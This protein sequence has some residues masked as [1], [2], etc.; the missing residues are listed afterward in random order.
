MNLAKTFKVIGKN[1]LAFLGGA[2]LGVASVI[3][4]FLPRSLEKIAAG[5][6]PL[7]AIAL[8]PV[9]LII[10]GLL[11]IVIGGFGAII[12][13]NIIKLSLKRRK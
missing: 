13:Y 6:E 1:I 3:F 8:V 12:I 10:Y 5:K 9:F 4:F 7:A 11:G 2:V